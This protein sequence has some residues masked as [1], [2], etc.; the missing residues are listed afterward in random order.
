M[1][2][3]SG[4]GGGD[5]LAGSSTVSSNDALNGTVS[6]YCQIKDILAKHY[7][8]VVERLQLNFQPSCMSNLEYCSEHHTKNGVSLFNFFAKI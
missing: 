2:D 3:E 7:F 8:N 1:D 6:V 5:D 4:S